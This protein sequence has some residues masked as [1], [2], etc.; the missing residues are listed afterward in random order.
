MKPAWTP[1]SPGMKPGSLGWLVG[2]GSTV[3][4]PGSVSAGCIS[5]GAGW[6]G[7]CGKASEYSAGLETLS[8]GEAL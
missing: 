5:Q 2:R 6:V 3:Q 1:G 4:A 7:G 8:G